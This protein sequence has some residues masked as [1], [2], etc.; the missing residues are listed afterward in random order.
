MEHVF[1]PDTIEVM[2]FV[3]GDDLDT[4]QQIGGIFLC[5]GNAVFHLAARNADLVDQLAVLG[6]KWMAGQA[7]QY[8]DGSGFN[9]IR[10]GRIAKQRPHV[11]VGQAAAC[12]VLVER[13]LQ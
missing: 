13:S 10:L 6:D 12:F 3:G 7:A 9:V 8:I 11:R 2:E 4:S 1:K 5:A